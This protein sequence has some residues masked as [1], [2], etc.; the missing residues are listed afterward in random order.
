MKQLKIY[1]V[2]AFTDTVFQGSPA[3]VCPLGYWLDDEILQAVARENNL[4]E[5]AF[6]VP[7]DNGFHIRWFTPTQEVPLCGHATLTSAFTIFTELEPSLQ[8]IR[9]ASKSG[10]L[11]VTRHDALIEMDFPAYTM[12]PCPS[13]PDHLLKGLRSRPREV[14]V[15]EKDPNY[16]VILESE[17]EVRRI[18]YI[19]NRNT[20]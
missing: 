10:P 15:V 20:I 13:P 4:A 3:A 14:H 11:R 6:F 19:F 2:D 5:T 7:G 16:Y 8:S 18:K 17:D 12:T 9:F 1:Q